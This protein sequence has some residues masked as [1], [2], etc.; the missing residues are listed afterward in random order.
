MS[1]TSVRW[2]KYD[3]LTAD[4]EG[5]DIFNA[6]T[7]RAEIQ[8]DDCADRFANDGQAWLHVVKQALAGEETHQRAL[9]HVLFHNPEEWLR[10]V[11]GSIPDA[12]AWWQAG[13]A[14]TVT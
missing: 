3:S 7:D 4:R 11:K 2:R 8:R 5:W 9:A 12:D 10:V 1:A 6:G 14:E 13:G